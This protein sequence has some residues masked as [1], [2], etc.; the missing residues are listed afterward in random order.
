MNILIAIIG[1]SLL[2]L[3]HEL[4]HF[5]LAKAVGVGVTEFSLGMG[6]R[7]LSF[8]KGETRYS[9]KLVPFGGSCAMV[10]EDEDAEADNAFNNKPAW[11]RFLVVAAGPAFNV[12]FAFLISLILVGVGGV[13]KPV[14]YQVEAGS[15]AEQAGVPLYGTVI[16]LNGRRIVRGRDIELYLLNHELTGEKAE[17]IA[18][19]ENGTRRT[20]LIDT[21]R[22]GYRIGIS[23]YSDTEQ[24]VLSSVT[25]GYPAAEA[26]LRAGD[27]L[28][29]VNGTALITGSALHEYLEAHPLDGSVLLI[30][31]LRDGQAVTAE[32]KPEFYAYEAL[33]FSAEYAYDDWRGNIPELVRYS[34]AEVRFWLSYSLM[35]L[36]MLV[37]GQVGIRDMS[38]PVGIVETIGTVVDDGMETGGFKDA[39]AN[40]LTM[41]VL[42]SANLGVMNLLPIPALDG[43]RLF[44]ILVEIIF[45]KP[46]PREKE[47]MIHGI[48]LI[49]LLILMAFIM[50]SDVLRL[51][52]K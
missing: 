43:G 30:E 24:P 52:G 41:L 34:L 40:L 32:V 35:S 48:G 14:I 3:S 5:L 12:I 17:L 8:T 2:I 23:Y 44:F 6:P 46:I 42:L 37:T 36:R 22:E 11:A 47:G 50:F 19:D 29:S 9:W 39:L 4:G 31:A 45:R 18:E 51:F 27:V 7:I 1:F 49:L 20:Y 38:G 15:G 26:G 33:G 21:H 28:T 10:G 16:S 25:E 13:N